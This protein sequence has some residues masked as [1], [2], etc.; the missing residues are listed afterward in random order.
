MLF[1]IF[2][3][4]IAILGAIIA[5]KCWRAKHPQV[6]LVVAAVS[7]VCTALSIGIFCLGLFLYQALP[8]APP[9]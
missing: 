1:L 3:I 2:L 7:L 5:W 8:V 4:P 6:A 9:G